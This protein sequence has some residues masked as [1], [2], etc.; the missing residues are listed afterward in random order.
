MIENPISFVKNTRTTYSIQYRK[1]FT[2]VLVQFADE[3][4]AWIPMDTLNAMIN[5]LMTI[6]AGSPL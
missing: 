5:R 2:E 3:D 1:N 6:A 4:P